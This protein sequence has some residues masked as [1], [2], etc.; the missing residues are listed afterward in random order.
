VPYFFLSHAHGDD[1]NYVSK[2]R[3]DLGAAVDRSAHRPPPGPTGA[4][5]ETLAAT[6]ED[7]ADSCR[8]FVALCSTRYFLSDACGR[9]WSVFT[10]RLR[11]YREST[12]R[13]APALIPVVWSTTRLLDH[14]RDV[15]GWPSAVPV[16]AGGDGDLSRLIRLGGRRR[17]YDALVAG[18]AERIVA[19]AAEHDIPPAAPRDGAQGAQNAFVDL[20]ARLAEAA[21]LVHIVVAAATREEMRQVRAD[22]QFYG[23]TGEDWAPYRPGETDPLAERARSFLAERLYA[24]DVAGLGGLDDRVD[25]AGR[26]NDILVLLVDAWV[27]RLARYRRMLSSV[28]RTG[29]AAILVPANLDDAESEGHRGELNSSVSRA[30]RGAEAACDLIIRSAIETP[31]GFETDLVAA[32]EEAKNHIYRRGQVFRR[33]PNTLAGRPILEGP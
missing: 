20:P 1:D 5:A 14:V 2:F 23:A 26:N 32:L 8:V 17:E 21:Q 4:R 27:T 33:P 31:V 25:R 28:G 6:A 13:E 15:D 30:F 19:T 22:V 12:G 24:L 10:A 11:R 16:V 3:R 18:L 9:Q 29:P 7:A